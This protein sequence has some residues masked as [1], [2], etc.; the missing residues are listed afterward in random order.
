MHNVIVV[1]DANVDIIVPYP[2]FLNE[3]RTLVDYPTPS[4][5]EEELL[6]IQ[7]LHCPGWEWEPALSV[8]L[9]K[10]ST[11]GTLKAIFRKKA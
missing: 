1:G 2:R 9:V 3:E 4:L 10:T 5:Q 8:P 11:E 6:P 7:R